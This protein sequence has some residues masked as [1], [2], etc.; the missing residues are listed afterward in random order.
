VRAGRIEELG[1]HR[2]WVTEHHLAPDVASS[3]PLTL[4][5]QAATRTRGLRLGAGGVMIRNHAPRFDDDVRETV[6]HL[7]GLGADGVEVFVL[8]AS[9]AT[10]VLAAREGLGLAVAGHVTP[11]DMDRAIAAYRERFR[12]RPGG[13]RPYVVLCLPIIVADSDD[14]AHRWHRCIQ[15]RYLDR[16]R[17]GGAPM[18]RPD[19]VDLDWSAGERYRVDGMLEAALVGSADTVRGQLLDVA[20]RLAP[21]EVM[22]MTDLPDP[23]VTTGSYRRLAEI[24]ASIPETVAAEGAGRR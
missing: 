7:D 15:Q 11:A 12:P 18:R 21:D 3:S 1:C 23:E 14:E 24:A 9:P 10:A 20:R 16:L 13:D 17:T 5:G 2:L 4:A 8:G 6:H 19:E 22:A